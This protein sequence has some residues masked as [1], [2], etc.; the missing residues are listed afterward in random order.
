[1]LGGGRW[2][3]AGALVAGVL[4]WAVPAHAHVQTVADRNDR[5]GP[6]DIRSARHAHSG[7]KVTHTI[8]TFGAWRPAL[9]GLR[10]PNFFALSISTDGDAPAERVVV[11]YSAGGRVTAR[12]YS[13]D[14]RFV[15]GATAAKPNARTVRISFLRS[16]LG[17]GLQYRWQALSFFASPRTCPRGCVDR[18]PNRGRILHDIRAP[19]VSFPVPG[20]PPAPTYDVSF[21]VSDAGGAGLAEWRL[22]QRDLGST[23]WNE[24]GT[25][26]SVGIQN[27]SFPA[28]AGDNDEFR[29][30]AVDKHG[31][32]TTSPVRIVSVPVDDGSFTFGGTWTAGGSPLDFMGTL[33][34][35][36]DPGATASYAFTGRHV[37]LV[38]PGGTGSA[39]VVIEGVIQPGINLASFTGPRQIVFEASFPTATPQT[40][41]LTVLGGPFPIDGI[42][43][44]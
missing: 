39:Q 11:V 43:V 36:G 25:G 28:A 1:M 5:P 23:T 2:A 4:V 35:A 9:L 26:T 40:L 21:T 20:V 41:V 3:L 18:A 17:T 12:I 24:V 44:R 6:L 42:I 27:V 16:R 38:A 22:E 31:N 15:A 10:T 32:T 37:A 14:G 33:R 7:S 13:G 30:V 29:V 8:T 19:V 34:T